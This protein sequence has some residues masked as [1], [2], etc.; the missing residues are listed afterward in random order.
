MP[1]RQPYLSE[2][3]GAILLPA[4]PCELTEAHARSLFTAEQHK[5]FV[6]EL[7]SLASQP[8]S[9]PKRSSLLEKA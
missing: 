5:D 8:N 7:L 1:E 2:L 4:D 3:P 9:T 6:Q